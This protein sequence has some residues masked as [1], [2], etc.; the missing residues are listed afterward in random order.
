MEDIDS[1]ISDHAVAAEEA[2]RGA[3]SDA[4]VW[5]EVEA[6]TSENTEFSASFLIFMVLA[7]LLAGVAILLDSTILLVG[8]MVVGPEFG[9]LAGLC[10]A[11]VQRRRA[12]IKR[13]LLPLVVG[14]PV[15][16]IATLLFALAIDATGLTPEGFSAGEHPNTLFI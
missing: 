9:P 13:S 8:A 10:V 6:R 1:L 2:A 7:C 11:I 4:V 16:I 12:L 15:G 3:P 14:F 5:E